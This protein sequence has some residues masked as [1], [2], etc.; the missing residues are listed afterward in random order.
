MSHPKLLNYF[1]SKDTL[2]LSYVKYTRE[3]MSKHCMEWFRAHSRKDYESNLAYM[4]AFMKYVADAPEG[5]LRPNATTQ[6]Y[7]LG[8]YNEEIGQM[9]SEEFREWREV[10][11]GCLVS[12]Y[13]EEVGKSEAEAMMILIA[14]TFNGTLDGRDGALE[15]DGS[16]I[17]FFKKSPL[18]RAF[19]GALGTSIAT[20]KE[21]ARFSI[22]DVASYS[23]YEG[24]F[25]STLQ[26]TLSDGTQLEFR[27]GSDLET[28]IIP[29]PQASSAPD[30][31]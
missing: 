23:L 11:E 18:V 9:V 17:A 1:D 24:A 7:V 19:F 3:Y 26:I 6:T 14:G 27:A 29:A 4:N 20:G 2:I 22:S 25:K 10:M 16:E 5:E 8:H 13:G 28:C 15:W 12:I 21:C 30:G 31:V